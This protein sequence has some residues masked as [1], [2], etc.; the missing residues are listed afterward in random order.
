MLGGVQ[1]HIEHEQ[2]SVVHDVLQLEMPEEPAADVVEV[3]AG[4]SSFAMRP[5]RAAA[6]LALDR[7]H[8]LNTQE[9]L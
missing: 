6:V 9:F 1:Q 4:T 5:R 7:I 2:E 3:A 8:D